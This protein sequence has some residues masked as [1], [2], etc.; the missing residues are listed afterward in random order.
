MYLSMPRVETGKDPGCPWL[1]RPALI[2][3]ATTTMPAVRAQVLQQ[4]PREA[5]VVKFS[6]FLF[7]AEI[8]HSRASSSSSS[9]F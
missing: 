3:T 6:E 1:R 2:D 5:R 8:A 4:A 7:F 9:C